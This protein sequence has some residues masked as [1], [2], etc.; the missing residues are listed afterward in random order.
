MKKILLVFVLFLILTGIVFADHPDDKL[1]LGVIGGWHGSWIAFNGGWGYTSFS[2]KIPDV[3]VFWALNL[4][5]NANYFWLGVS[6]DVYLYE[7]PIVSEINLH[8]M[9]GV[10]AWVNLGL[11]NAANF[12]LGARVPVGISWHILDF[13]ELFTDIA[14]SLGLRVVPDFYFPSGGWPLEIGIR[15]WL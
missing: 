4:G 1:G 3:P 5:F 12:E 15:F 8:W 9:V 7:R 10:G 14:P 11:G 6:G 13:L 2:L